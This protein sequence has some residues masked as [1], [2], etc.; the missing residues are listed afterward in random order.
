MVA[1]AART[2]KAQSEAQLVTNG[3]RAA[4]SCKRSKPLAT[5]SASVMVAMAA[6]T[7]KAQSEAQPSH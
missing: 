6:G 2:G 7:G 3:I 4:S 5:A 1:M